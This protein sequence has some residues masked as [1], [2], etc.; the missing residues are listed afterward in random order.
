MPNFTT[1]IFDLDGT[2]L[3]TLDDLADAVN[4]SLAAFGYP[5]RTRE[6]V[7]SF[8]GNGVRLLIVR[9]LPQ[10]DS[11]PDFEEV[12][13]YFRRYYSAHSCEKTAPY[14]GILDALATLRARG[15]KIAVVSNKMESAVRD[16][17]ASFFPGLVEV[18]IGD[19]EGRP[20]KPAP[21]GVFAALECLGV[22]REG[23]VYIGDSDV[24][25]ETAQNAALPCISVLWGFRD[26]D[27]LRSA[28]ADSFAK[29]TEELLS[30]FEKCTR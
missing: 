21:E 18:A 8:V 24:D 30:Y 5:A 19:L 22:G 4:A 14:P 15:V 11:N 13:A 25:V 29:D 6:Q 20:R 23:A 28:G 10:G 26:E 16:L 17:T 2:L 12:Y 27:C 3:D 1:A 9:A 7:R